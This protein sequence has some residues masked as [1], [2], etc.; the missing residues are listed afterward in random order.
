FFT[1]KRPGEGTG[2]GLALC[3]RIAEEHGGELSFET[4]PGAGSEFA[5]RLPVAT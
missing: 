5:L 4:A 1:T 2:L 3:R